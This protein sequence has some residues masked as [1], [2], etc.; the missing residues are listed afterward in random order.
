[1]RAR[2]SAMLKWYSRPTITR[3]SRPVRYSSTAAYWPDRP[4]ERRTP[5]GSAATSMPLTTARPESGVSSV[6]RIRTA[7]VLP[8][9]LGPSSPSTDPAGTSRSTPSRARTSPDRLG[10]TLTRL[11]AVMAA[12]P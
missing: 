12:M 8:A 5:W 6:V 3:F 10:N 11:S 9:P 1:M 2:E 7:V 4:I